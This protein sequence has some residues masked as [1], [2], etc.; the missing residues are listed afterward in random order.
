MLKIELDNALSDFVDVI[1]AHG[2]DSPQAAEYR[3]RYAGEQELLGLLDE[4]VKLQQELSPPQ[5]R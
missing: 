2:S 4:A 5:K 3:Q 1:N